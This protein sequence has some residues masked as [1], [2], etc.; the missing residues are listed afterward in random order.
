[1]ELPTDLPVM[2]F[3][4][5]TAWEQWLIAHP[6][7]RGLWLQIAKQATGIASVNYAQA[8]DVALCH[9]WIDGQKKGLDAQF[10][11]QRFTPR[12]PRSLWSKINQAH[13]ERLTAA[14]RMAPAGLREVQAAKA[15]GR[16]EAAYQGAGSMQV[17]PELVAALRG[18]RKAK[19]FFD[20]LDKTNRYAFCWRVQTAKKPETRQARAATFVQML[21]RGEK[22]HGA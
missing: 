19:A 10:F 15:D 9:G 16:W 22:I 8:L 12:R 14:G 1:M 11:L 17:P 13:V 5:A 20:A 3:V 6:D 2:H 21:A 7:A 18:N 4:D